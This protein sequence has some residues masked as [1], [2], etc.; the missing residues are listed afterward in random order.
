MIFNN[1]PLDV[2][3]EILVNIPSFRQLNKQFHKEGQHAFIQRYCSLPISKNEFVKYQQHFNGTIFKMDD[4][5]LTAI[6]LRTDENKNT[7]IQLLP[8]PYPI[9]SRY[10][11]NCIVYT[12]SCLGDHYHSYEK[13]SKCIHYICTPLFYDLKSTFEILQNRN[14]FNIDYEFKKNYLNGLFKSNGSDFDNLIVILKYILYLAPI[15]DM[16]NIK[17]NIPLTFYCEKTHDPNYAII[18]NELYQ[19]CLYYYQLTLSFL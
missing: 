18:F 8:K 3:I 5:G 17:L 14:C 15:D 2:Q 6:Y 13:M 4:Y 1:F 7:A 12:N 11:S 9:S 16:K 10:Y 19:L